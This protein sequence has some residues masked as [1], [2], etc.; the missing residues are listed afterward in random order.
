M[1]CQRF[2]GGIRKVVKFVGR[3]TVKDTDR[4]RA[5]FDILEEKDV[6]IEGEGLALAWES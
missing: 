4:V 3:I 1:M 6:E 2:R 5:R